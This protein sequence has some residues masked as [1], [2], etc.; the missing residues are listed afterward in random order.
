[1]HEGNGLMEV[2]EVVRVCEKARGV[3]FSD[4]DQWQITLW[5]PNP[6]SFCTFSLKW[7]ETLKWV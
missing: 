2:R 5:V 4:G 3:F 1:M 6:Y 7:E